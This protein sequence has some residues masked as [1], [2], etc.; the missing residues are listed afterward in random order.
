[1]KRLLTSILAVSSL[2][3]ADE[4]KFGVNYLKMDYVET[5]KEGKFLDSEKSEYKDIGGFNLSYTK[6]LTTLKQEK[7]L[8]SLELSLRY[9]KG[10]T[11]YD[12]FLQSTI[13]GQIISPYKTLTNNEIIEPK[14]RIKQTAY[15]SNYDAS[16]FVSYG[17][18]Q[19]ER[20]ITGPYGLKEIYDW[21]YYDVGISGTFYDGSWDIG[22]E[23]AYQEAIKPKMKAYI[24]GGLNFDL[25]D[26]K[27]YYYKIPLGY[28][29]NKN[30]RLET[31]YEYNQWKIKASNVV[32]G[33]YEPDSTTKNKI[34]GFNISFIF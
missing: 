32:S 13:T 33:F 11:K 29:F 14:I 8:T 25:G 2:A 18:R 23:I 4:I 3:L 15:S 26:T 10:D 28:N 1:M 12:G 17:Y 31:F 9:F 19:W 30:W 24:K 22:F 20:V 16:I 21:Q 34:I 7:Q 6:H 27:G 5:S